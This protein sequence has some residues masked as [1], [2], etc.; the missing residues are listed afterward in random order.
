MEEE[1]I[2]YLFI[3]CQYITSIWRII[4]HKLQINSLSHHASEFFGDWRKVNIGKIV[5]IECDLTVMAV[6]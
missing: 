4:I 5:R 1:K 6:L 3:H 2:H